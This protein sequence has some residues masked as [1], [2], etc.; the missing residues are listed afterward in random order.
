LHEPTAREVRRMKRRE[1]AQFMFPASHSRAEEYARRI[2]QTLP[3][4]LQRPD[5]R[6]GLVEA[7]TNAILHGAFGIQRESEDVERYLDAIEDAER[8]RAGKT[9][10]GVTVRAGKRG[11]DVIVNDFGPGFDWRRALRKIGRGLSILHEVFED[12]RWNAGGNCV[13]LTIGEPEKRGG[14]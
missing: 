5:V 3:P 1:V 13:R 11:F 9:L 2:E 4:E 10:I 6:A 14:K 7:I 8:T 12:V